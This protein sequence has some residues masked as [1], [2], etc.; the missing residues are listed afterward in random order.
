MA[1]TLTNV[2]PQILAQGL[3]ALRQ[4]AVMTRLVNRAYEGEAKQK[5]SVVEIPVPSAIAARDVTPSVTTDSNVDSSPTIVLVTLDFWKE[6]PFHLTDKDVQEAMN[7]FV[8]MQASEAVKSLANAVDTYIMSKHVRFFRATGTA[9]TTPFNGSLTAAAEA[10]RLLNVEL[11]PMQDRRAVLD[12]SAESNLLINANILDADKRGDQ[13][14]IIQGEVGLKLGF[15]WFMDQ[16]VATYTPGTAWITGWSAGG[17]AASGAS[18]ISALFTNSGTVKI[19]DIFSLGNEQYVIT[20]NATAVTDT[21]LSL[22]IYPPLRA[23][24]ASASVLTIGAGATAYTYN[25]AFHRDAFAWASRPLA[26]IQGLGSVM[27][28]ASDPVSGVALR[29]EISRQH[30]Q[31]T[32]SYDILGGCNVVRREYGVK[33][34]G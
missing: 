28:A 2:T 4:N 9:G 1:N 5:G 7:G 23:A 8:P 34:K 32:F 29:L 16:N 25:L 11:A 13:F 26:D 3:M 6:A 15:Q 22:T 27:Q 20:A 17:A 19:G 12:P 10:R 18:T 31:T 30:K 33:I 24:L 21:A 14:G